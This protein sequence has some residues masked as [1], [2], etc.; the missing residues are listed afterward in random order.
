LLFSLASSNET[1]QERKGIAKKL[2]GSFLAATH[3]VAL[4]K[5]ALPG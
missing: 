5:F 4:P 2:V 1:P 3:G